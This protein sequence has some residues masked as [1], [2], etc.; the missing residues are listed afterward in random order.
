MFGNSRRHRPPNPHL[1]SGTADPNAA[2]AAA[3]AFMSASNQRPNRTLSSA[4]AAA[5]L[6]A[7]PQTPTNVGAVQTKR[8][9]RRSASVSSSGSA[10]ATA[11]RPTGQLERRPSSGSMTER[12][13]RSPSP[14]RSLPAQAK[15]PQPPV[16]Q[17]PSNHRKSASSST[18]GV[19]MQNFRTASQKMKSGHPSWYTE[20][21]GDLSNVRTSDAPMTLGKSP[22]SK[23][24]GA[25]SATPRPDSRSS[26]VNFSYP[27]GFHAHSPP[28]S[29]T[30]ASPPQWNSPPPQ[31]PASPPRSSIASIS[32]TGGK[33]E[34]QMVYDPNSRRMVPKAHVDATV[35]P[36]VRE[37][38]GRQPRKKKRDGGLQRAGSQ[39]AKGTVARVKGA[40]IDD[41]KREREPPKREQPVIEGPPTVDEASV[42]EEPVVK[43]II[44]TPQKKTH[45]EQTDEMQPLTP[46]KL[47]GQ[48][49]L[50]ASRKTA[51][52]KPTPPS[53]RVI[54][55]RP[56]VVE[57]E[58]EEVYESISPTSRPQDALEAL[59][60]ESTGRPG[61]EDP[62]SYQPKS[63][64]GEEAESQYTAHSQ[65]LEQTES[66]PEGPKE[67]KTMV[68]EN[69]PV[70]ELA[71]N[72]S[73][74][75]RSASNSPV[76]Q[77][78][79]AT[80]PSEGL[81][82]RHAPLPRSASPIKP[83][84]K[85]TSPS[86][87][88]ASPSD[89]SSD[90]S[91]TQ[92][93]PTI[94]RKKSVR[95]SFDDRNTMVVGEAAPAE[96]SDEPTPP[97]PQQAKRPW[98]SNIG[99]SKRREFTLEDD[100][101]MKPR[102]ALP[103]FGSIRDKKVRETGERPLVRPL[104]PVY[105][106]A[107]PSSPDLRPQS[108][109][110]LADSETTE[111]PP[112]GQSSDHALASLLAQDQTSR[113][114]ANISRFREPLPPIVTSVEGG[115][116][117]S[118][119]TGSSDSDD[120]H[121]DNAVG[122]ND[123]EV[124]PSGTT[125]AN[126]ITQPGAVNNLQNG[127]TVSENTR[128]S[129]VPQQQ[130][131]SINIPPEN[132]PGISVTQPTPL[133]PEHNTQPETPMHQHSSPPGGFPDDD[134]DGSR[135]AQ[136]LAKKADLGTSPAET[137]FE[138]T[139]TVHPAQANL[140]PQTTLATTPPL[141]VDDDKSTDGSEGSIYS[142][143]Q[144]DLSDVDGDGFMS[145]DAIVES[146]ISKAASSRRHELPGDANERA[147]TEEGESQAAQ[148]IP[149]VPP[150]VSVPQGLTEW[151]KAKYFW[152][153]LT[154]EKRLQLER[155]AMED[156]GADGDR[157]EVALPIRRNSSRK[158]TYEVK[159]SDTD[160][161]SQGPGASNPSRPA[162]QVKVPAV[163][164]ESTATT[165]HDPTGSILKQSRMRT[166]LREERPAKATIAQPSSGMQKTMRSN[167]GTEQIDQPSAHRVA[168]QPKKLE[169][170]FSKPN[171]PR[172]SKPRQQLVSHESSPSPLSQGIHPALQ[173]RASDA[174]DSS[175]KRSRA[176]PN[177]G[178]GFRSTMRQPVTSQSNHEVTR[179][180]GRFS[181][182][183][184]SPTGSPFRRSS[185][186]S[187]MGSHP[188]GRMRHT[189][190]S[191]SGSSQEGKHSSL[192]M[193][194]FGW[195]SKEQSTKNAKRSSRF[196]DS[197]D[198]DDGMTS[199]FRSRFEDSSDEEDDRPSSSRQT[200]PLT[201]GTLRASATA[202][203]G[204]RKATPVPEE[205]EDSPELPDSDDDVDMP[206]PLQSPKSRTAAIAAARVGLERPN[207]SALG[208]SALTRTRSGRGGFTSSVSAPALSTD[209]KR[210]SFLGILR[211]NKKA[212]Q[213]GKIQ[214]SE[215]M[216]S[217]ARRDT[218]LERNVG[219][220]R[221]IRGD[222]VSSPRLQKKG[223]LRRG[224]DWPL[225]EPGARPSSAGN[226]LSQSSRPASI[227]RPG[228][229]GRRSMSL[230]SHPARADEPGII[231]AD[232]LG[233]KKK[234]KFGALRRMFRLDE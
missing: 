220:L 138:P 65:P 121:L 40:T 197:S 58:P 134:S 30:S 115:G 38:A 168:V 224:E 33:S 123:T 201:R 177:K 45:P 231:T 184:L 222:Q 87:R 97:S 230:G 226:L 108:S 29:P 61:V 27:I 143:A 43:A 39:L 15:Q 130:P 172:S 105:S 82:V 4:A 106:P 152:R 62:L 188:A 49:S 162:D 13:F 19:G 151:E 72:D 116:Y 234:K 46:G 214:R 84:L 179:G 90:P 104:E 114:E 57:E 66:P 7:R 167:G 93:E 205:E 135:G 124:V 81:P 98:Y 120:E 16:P 79:F 153:S 102:P 128:H 83:A 23:S 139:A 132:I 95:V 89:N 111:E 74:T 195:P 76:R 113:I 92:Q 146:P 36:Q 109:S 22:M 119:S 228:P 142:D 213:A 202:P 225:S 156:A 101:V 53:N 42:L 91:T 78:R 174:S 47:E 50:L 171:Q 199:G 70:A 164:S 165:T 48:S 212:D 173:R 158:K 218:K 21:S 140:L 63:Q 18:A 103:S 122:T 32:S 196:G 112:L 232:G 8:T 85:R 194:S 149:I 24:E 169:S 193:P 71:R 211:R 118:D 159:K 144:E 129:P 88:D 192:H 127:S 94:P 107:A 26:S 227:R 100:E 198:D 1:T 175:F 34:Q 145:L 59:G 229:A 75:R 28:A 187:D 180:S 160:T 52:E 86:P 170:S 80:G 221:G 150:S 136:P 125:Q 141:A 6:R 60:T 68:I 133:A 216:E 14:R 131:M 3:S 178:F 147:N 126:Q 148:G 25:A 55:K 207:A 185:V 186:H 182:R 166:S 12:T 161:Q 183:S 200:R 219:Q 96:K 69:K 191:N 154:A 176:T 37:V 2:T 54:G 51:P 206:S 163:Q 11:G 44:T 17:I 181:L 155:E 9:I 10:A 215:P 117:M 209:D 157:E 35:D 73:S 77:A 56:S 20:P 208:T 41:N 217:A 5:A 204:L 67:K 99:R 31:T 64:I 223:S 190:R 203:V 137:I 189:L 110:T 210:N 233:Q